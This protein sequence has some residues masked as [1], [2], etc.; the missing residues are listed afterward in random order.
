[1]QI[2]RDQS[3]Y[4]SIRQNRLKKKKKVVARDKGHYNFISVLDSKKIQ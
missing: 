3:W 1:M 4:T 2:L